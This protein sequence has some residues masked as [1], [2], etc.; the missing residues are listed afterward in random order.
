MKHIIAGLGSLAL[1]AAVTTSVA[2][3]D[4]WKEYVYTGDGFAIAAPSEPA[5]NSQPIYVTGGTADAHIYSSAAGSNAALMLFVFE[6]HNNDR[7]SVQ[8]IHAEAQD[9]ALGP[10]KGKLRARTELALGKY[11]GAELEFEAQHPDLDTKTHQVR[12]RYYVVGR[13]IYHLMAIA[14]VG[15]PF[16]SD[17]DRWFKSFRLTTA[18]DH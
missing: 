12:S 11:R 6:R 17:A 5:R 3:T 2:Q 16:P 4:S 8:Q 18:A 9:G 7:R 10:V 14:P 13:K 15:E 1:L